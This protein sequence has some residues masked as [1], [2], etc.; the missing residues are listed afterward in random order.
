MG[1][2]NLLGPRSLF[3]ASELVLGT[4]LA[5][6]PLL[7]GGAPTWS[8]AVIF[9]LSALASLLILCATWSAPDSAGRLGTLAC[10]AAILSGLRLLPTVL[11]SGG[12]GLGSIEALARGENALHMAPGAGFDAALL[13]VIFGLIAVSSH[14]LSRS[15]HGASRRLLIWMG[16]GGCVVLVIG[17]VHVATGIDLVAWF[18]QPE[19]AV[20]ETPMASTLLNPNHLGGYLI[21]LVGI[22]LATAELARHRSFT[23]LG[24]AL[25]FFSGVGAILTFSHSTLAA[26]VFLLVF[27]AP[28]RLRR[29]NSEHLLD[30]GPKSMISA[31]VVGLLLAALAL[32]VSNQLLQV[33]LPH[34]TSAGHAQAAKLN[35]FE[36]A[37]STVV[38]HPWIGV[39][40][41]AFPDLA[42]IIQTS[43]PNTSY[44][45]VENLPLQ[46]VVDHGFLLGGAIAGYGLWLITRCLR[47]AWRKPWML[48]IMGSIGALILQNMAD[49]NLFLVGTGVPA[50]ALLAIVAAKGRVRPPGLQTH[51]VILPLLIGAG[52]LLV[53]PSLQWNRHRVLQQT[54][55]LSHGNPIDANE[56]RKLL[57]YYPYA[58]DLWAILALS[59]EKKPNGRHLDLYDLARK[60][61]PLH[62]FP[63]FA[64]ARAYQKAGRISDAAQSY[65]DSCHFDAGRSE[66]RLPWVRSVPALP[67][68]LAVLQGMAENDVGCMEPMIQYAMDN[69][70]Y[71]VAYRITEAALRARPTDPRMLYWHAT[72]ALALGPKYKSYMS[73]ITA[74]L[75]GRYSERA[76]GF[77]LQGR[78]LEES[79]PKAAMHMFEAAV[80]RDPDWG[81]ASQRWV[82]AT[83]R[84]QDTIRFQR[85]LAALHKSI[86]DPTRANHTANI[87]KAR[88]A[89]VAGKPNVA[90]DMFENSLQRVKNRPELRLLYLQALIDSGKTDYIHSLC[91]LET[92]DQAF[93]SRVQTICQTTTE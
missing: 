23:I 26:L 18:Y 57:R 17:W 52:I 78:L 90:V 59:Q 74:K 1:K 19:E 37:W 73:R 71:A 63:A 25:A 77:V 4:T 15:G 82:E 41:G 34:A 64:A 85:A 47:S 43:D 48:Y 11:S 5:I 81:E 91:Q 42:A 45:Y 8:L 12:S 21:L 20:R 35:I 28:I 62:Y 58:G 22:G 54:E 66:L 36:T 55:Q 29:G 2:D 76:E 89:L 68:A 38:A 40:P 87:Y 51:R 7:L 14:L 69:R 84:T 93:H 67:N 88:F 49:Y 3:R 46:L 44:T 65:T 86:G 53:S 75:M 16:A 33:V 61:A 32:I 83:L 80:D 9:G 30:T 24:D 79:N 31:A 27:I 50:T 72:S 70:A 92:W 39:G 6:S 56:V 60:R 10:I 13:L